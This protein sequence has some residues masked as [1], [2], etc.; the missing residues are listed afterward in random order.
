LRC[1]TFPY[2]TDAMSNDLIEGMCWIVERRCPERD[3]CVS[4]V[5][6][7]DG[8]AQWVRV[9]GLNLPADYLSAAQARELAGVLTAAADQLAPPG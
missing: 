6:A 8:S 4:D 3:I 2:D 7:G 1:N 5:V 9:E